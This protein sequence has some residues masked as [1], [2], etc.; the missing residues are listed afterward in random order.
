MKPASTIAAVVLATV[1]WM[2]GWYVKPA[3]EI[4]VKINPEIERLYTRIILLSPIVLT[5]KAGC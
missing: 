5:L 4:Y 3:C 1:I 2:V